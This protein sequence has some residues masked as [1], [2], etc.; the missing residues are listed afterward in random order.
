MLWKPYDSTFFNT[1][2]QNL[3]VTDECVMLCLEQT[4]YNR[5]AV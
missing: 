4:D 2:A 1:M 3:N 5:I